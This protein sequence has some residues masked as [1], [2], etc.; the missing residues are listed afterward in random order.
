MD[1]RLLEPVRAVVE[2]SVEDIELEK[3][4]SIRR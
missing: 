4:C 2:P 3:F 1:C